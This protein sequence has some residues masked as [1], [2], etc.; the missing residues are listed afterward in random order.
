MSSRAS[1]RA[2]RRRSPGDDIPLARRSRPLQPQLPSLASRFRRT[3]LLGLAVAISSAVL[4]LGPLRP[5][6]TPP[7]V[8]G[9]R[10]R[11]SADG[12][13]LGHFPIPRPR[14]PA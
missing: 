6:L 14:N 8:A 12:R 5:W 9:L 3:L 11:L 13:L 2:R 4:V 1:D 7:P 10:A